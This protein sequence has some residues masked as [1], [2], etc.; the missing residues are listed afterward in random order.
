MSA[1]LATTT[2]T[3]M[4]TNDEPFM[5]NVEDTVLAANIPGHIDIAA[6]GGTQGANERQEMN[7]LI[8]A[9]PIGK[10]VSNTTYII[11]DNTGQKYEIDWL[12]EFKSE[13]LFSFLNHIEAG[14]SWVRGSLPSGI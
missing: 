13:G 14:G 10:D 6:G 3:F 2:L 8:F 5:S 12:H 1:I 9:E 11:D 7:F 4:E